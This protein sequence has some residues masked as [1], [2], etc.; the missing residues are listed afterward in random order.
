MAADVADEA[1]LTEA[2]LEAAAQKIDA[3]VLTTGE[4][5][6]S[7]KKTPKRRGKKKKISEKKIDEPARP[8][9]SEWKVPQPTTEEEL[10][11]AIEALKG[12][13][14]LPRPPIPQC[15]QGLE[16][17]PIKGRLAK[18]QK[19]LNSFQ[20]NH[21]GTRYFPI[22]KNRGLIK[23]TTTAK[24]IMADALPIQC[25]EAVFLG[26]YLTCEWRDV[27]RVPISLKSV[28]DGHVFR[29]IILAIRHK[30]KW[31]A[32]GL[33]R[34]KTLA[35]KQIKFVGL[36]ALIAD[37][38]QAYREV[39]HELVK[40]YVG[41]P[42][43]H[44][45]F[46]PAAIKWRVLNVRLDSHPWSMVK[47]VLD[48]FG[49]ETKTIWNV[50][51]ELGRLPDNFRKRFAVDPDN[52]EDEDNNYDSSE[53]V[54][55]QRRAERLEKKQRAAEERKAVAQAKARERTIRKAPLDTRS[56][57]RR[58][59]GGATAT[60]DGDASSPS[61]TSGVGG[62]G[63]PP[64]GPSTNRA[65]SRRRLPEGTEPPPKPKK[66]P[67][68]PKRGAKGLDGATHAAERPTTSGGA[69]QGST[70]AGSGAAAAKRGRTA[71]GA[72]ARKAPGALHVDTSRPTTSSRRPQG[73]RSRAAAGDSEEGSGVDSDAPKDVIPPS[74]SVNA[75]MI[76]GGFLG[77]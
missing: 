41:F 9:E 31:G 45:P 19:Y 34:K 47:P 51:R 38:A 66:P 33:S 54:K 77:V 60:A 24:T 55:K 73:G 68:T 64:P 23:V 5:R 16:K 4:E 1:A 6:C 15:P 26:V 10:R 27:D 28:V 18:L 13:K 69:T 59:T 72:S 11:K 43:S 2:A 42:F 50:F 63:T 48:L 25:V 67:K 21:T 74:P 58:E 40:V 49:R 53:E 17:E 3:A 14:Q 39:W 52:W 46:S 8:S 76:R 12:N 57:P 56:P 20:Y 7:P 70:A 30:D 65:R 29:H 61:R 32:L 37:Y 35:F 71:A 36:G 44:D 62:T 22:V 75:S